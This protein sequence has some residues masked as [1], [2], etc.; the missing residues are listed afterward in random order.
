MSELVQ[1]LI[2]GAILTGFGFALTMA[3]D[4]YK[5][6]RDT[7][8]R[9]RA[10][11]TAVNEELRG[12]ITILE[13]N[14]KLLELEISGLDEKKSV[15]KPLT[16]VDNGSW[17]IVKINPP[18]SIAQDADTLTKIRTLSIRLRG[19]FRHQVLLKRS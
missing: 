11:T 17:D 1:G 16:P 18:Q 2:L 13:E 19:C 12:N 7:K 14:K 3:W 4:V 6:R 9:D 5:Y 10:V 15:I 8:A